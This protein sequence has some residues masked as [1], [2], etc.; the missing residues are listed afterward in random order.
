[1][2]AVL[3][4]AGEG[5]RLRPLTF[6][7]PKHLLPAAGRP[8]LDHVLC[9]LAEAGVT[10]AVFVVAPHAPA[11]RQFIGDG[12]RWGMSVQFAVQDVPRGL[13]DAV[14]AA[15]AHVAGERFLVYLGDTLLSGGVSEF[16]ASFAASE[17]QASLIVRPV[18]DPRPFGVVVV[19]GG[20]V[21][22]LVEKPADPPSNLCIVG[23]YGFGPEIFDSIQRITPSARGELEITDAIHDLLMRGGRVECH[24][25][26]SFW[27]DAGSA[28]ALLGA[29]AHYIAQLG[30]RVEGEVVNCQLL[31]PVQVQPGAVVRDSVLHGPCLICAQAVV[32]ESTLGPNVSVGAGSTVRRSRLVRAILSEQCVVEDAPAGLVDTVLGERV[33]VAGLTG[34]AGPISVVVGDSGV[35]RGL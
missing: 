34:A 8:V 26:D 30:T 5:T 22:R 27:A 4:C 19:E 10:E 28:E 16:V 29:N 31:G 35:V 3:L 1:M 9:A 7:R 23:V 13:A 14:W 6:A 12:S 2:K 15:R 20:R 24:V 11:L 25:T 21:Q 18:E 32:E 33:R 17:A